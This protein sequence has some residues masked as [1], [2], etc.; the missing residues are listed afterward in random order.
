M[1]KFAIQCQGVIAIDGKVLRR[2]FEKAGGRSALHMVSAWGCQR[3]MVLA[4]IA[5]HAKSNEIPVVRKLLEI[6]SLKR[7]IVTVD[8]LNCQRSIAEQIVR[9]SGDHALALKSNQGSRHDNA[10]QYLG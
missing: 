7:T 10:R 4:Q 3:R 8:A 2:S 6:L 5:I 9:Q 1:S